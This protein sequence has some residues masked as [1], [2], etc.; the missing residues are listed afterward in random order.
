MIL[1]ITGGV[2][3]GKSTVLAYLAQNYGAKVLELDRVAEE[4]QQPGGAC[5]EDMLRLLRPYAAAAG[6][7]EDILLEDGKFD[8]KAVAA[9]VFGDKKLLEQLNGIIH[10]A[11]REYVTDCV[12]SA[13]PQELTVIESALLLDEERYDEMCD[14]I[15]YIYAPEEVR[16]ERLRK[17]RGYSDDKITNIMNSQKSDAFFREHCEFI[18]DTSSNDVEIMYRQIDKGLSLHGIL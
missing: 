1:G 9:L 3:A 15:W 8:R 16:R 12:R 6:R 11:V 13:S 2:G 14:E 7:E 17:S 18:V 5:Y 4:L 10:P